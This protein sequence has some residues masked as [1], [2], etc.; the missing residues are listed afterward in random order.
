MLIR[1]A[2][3]G[4]FITG[5]RVLDYS[6]SL[7]DVKYFKIDDIFKRGMWRG[8]KFSIYDKSDFCEKSVITGHS[9]IKFGCFGCL[10]KHPQFF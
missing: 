3:D 8:R 6:N 7:Y 2:W 9:D 10:N 1:I 5:D 4:D